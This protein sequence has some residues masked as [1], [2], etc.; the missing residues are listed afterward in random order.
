MQLSITFD[1]DSSRLPH[2]TDERLAQLWHIAQAN[3]APFGERSACQFTEE[4]G[5]E[6]IRRFLAAT[7]PELWHH[8]GQ[9]IEQA[10]QMAAQASASD[11]EGGA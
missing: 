2:F 1:L 8:Q 7:R 5:R 10:R 4:V 6:I 9:H 3:P 11:V